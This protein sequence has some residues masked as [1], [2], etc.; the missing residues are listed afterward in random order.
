MGHGTGLNSSRVVVNL[1]GDWER[2]V[3]GKFV[4]LVR[5]PSSLRPS[6]E[7]VLRRTFL[8]PRLK[9]HE[10]AFLRF[11]AVNYHSRVSLNGSELGATIP[12]VPQ[13]FEGTGQALE[14]RN[15]VELTVVDAGSGAN[16]EGKNE[17]EYGTP[18]GW[19]SYGGIVRDAYAEIRPATFI[20]NVR[21]GYRFD[22]GY[23]K[24]QC[25]ARVWVSSLDGG[26]ADCEVALYWGSS[27]VARA[28]APVQLKV[29]DMSSVDLRFE[30]SD[31][32]LWSPD[33][34]NLYELRAMLKSPAGED[35]WSSR[36]G[37]REIR[38]EGRNFLLNGER[39]VLAGVCRHDMW[40]DQGFTLT[41]QQQEKD[42][43][44]I[45]ALGANFVRL[46][47][48]PHDRRIIELADEIGLLVSEEPGIWQ[49]D[50][51]RVGSAFGDLALRV[52][53]TTIRRDWNS[54]SVMAW[55]LGNESD[56]TA[57][58]LERG[59]ELCRRL[60]PVFRPVSAAH[61]E[62]SVKQAKDLFDRTGL[63]FYDWH[64]YQFSEDK[65]EKL[66]QEF[67][68]AKP[69]TFT[70]WGWEEGGHGDWFYERNFDGLRRQ[71]DSGNVA[72]HV[73]WS[74]NDMRQY[75]RIDWATLDGILLSGAVTEDRGIRQ[76]IYSRLGGLFA[77][78]EETPEYVPPESPRVL[79]LRVVPF[80]PGGRY[81]AVDLQGVV[82]SAPAAE[83]WRAFESRLQAF[84]ERAAMAE[85]QWTRTG[86]GFRLWSTPAIE[87]AGVGFRSAVF[88]GSVRPLVLTPEVPELTIPIDQP[89]SKLHVLG[90]VTLPDGYPL[91]GK[92]G[93][94]VAVYSLV[95]ADAR[96][97]DLPV[98]N[99]LEVAR[100]NR[101]HAATRIHAVAIHAQPVLEYRKD[102][103]REQ[104]QFLLW[105]VAIRPRRIRNLR[106]KLKSA[107][108]CLAIL[109]ITTE[110]NAT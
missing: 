11:H 23:E 13:E 71:A 43:R 93:E 4:D 70:E 91:E 58:Y 102:V 9:A 101:I 29:R 10:R 89:C 107:Q 30:A 52:L 108:S 36:T 46:V 33:E 20:D 40:K 55:L 85:N 76:P 54:P 7:Y 35:A 110:Q 61:I 32:A 3:H 31:L 109:A 74:W 28:K 42:M 80:S 67:G 6:G 53:E 44:M 99:G 98:R 51:P 17:V 25:T 81:A 95:G 90:Q 16:G 8:L 26:E 2:R 86:G 97:E 14:A 22:G 1:N 27:E 87:I 100:S 60:D 18:G 72:G 34:P 59:R 94:T 105:S 39:L 21:F 48:Y 19:E 65:F 56:F 5:V 63:D 92:P 15:V 75:T 77:G 62:G 106:C 38:I 79:P 12:Y 96:S 41:P 57:R 66:P 103:V 84:W 45:K 73:F 64:A 50:F 47:H 49:V 83:S 88:D 68:P 104:Y 69:L 37:F 82:E 78:R 24:A